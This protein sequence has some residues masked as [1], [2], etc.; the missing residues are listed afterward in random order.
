MP[1]PSSSPS[2]VLSAVRAV[3]LPFQPLG[4]V[5]SITL[6]QALSAVPD[7][8]KARGR[9]HS[10]QSILFLAVGAVLA[11]A[12]SYAAIAQWASHADAPVT[13]CGASPHAATFARVLAAVEVSFLQRVLTGWV[14]ARRAGAQRTQVGA[15]HPR[16]EDRMVLAFDG[17]TLRGARIGDGGQAKLVA[18]FDHTHGLVLAQ[19]EVSGGDE[20]A[21]FIPTLDSLPDLHHVV[22]TADALHCQ[23][24]H[25]TY[26]HGRGAH[27][28]F[29]VKGNQ[30]GLRR[31]LAR[32]P[33]AQ[34]PGLIE[35]QQGHGR[36]ESRSI[37][38]IDLDGAAEADRFPH[39]A[40]AIK[41]IRRRRRTGKTHPSVETVYALTS[42]DHRNA[43]P[44]LLAS[45]IRS[46]WTIENRLH[47]VRD[48]TE[49]ED[50]SSV[51]TGNGPQVMAALRNTAI[52][53][54]RLRG[55]T[56]IAAAHRHFSY[57]PAEVLDALTA[58]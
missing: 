13:V 46:H 55:G 17:K 48:V 24:A 58:A 50:H 7:P 51:R 14:L 40:R 26:L 27:Y 20:L 10:L 49:G 42:L 52:N 29:T 22:V 41:V 47:W 33:W 6:L 56:N 9:R 43:D 32:L 23:R 31:A 25:A 28:L 57:R 30:P 21:A 45:W 34:A 37:K 2:L 54:I 5:E 8:R 12:R 4:V 19:A 1:A 38:V 11:G 3:E 15:A 16:A 18:V 39:G 44:R 53:I 36:A 35:R